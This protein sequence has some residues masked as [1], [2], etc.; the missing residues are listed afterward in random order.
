MVEGDKWL[1]TVFPALVN[2]L[3]IEF[4]ALFV[5]LSVVTIRENTCPVDRESE[6]SETHLSK[7]GNIFTEVMIEINRGVGGIED[8]I[9]NSWAES[10]RSVDIAA[11]E[12]I[13]NAQSLAALK[14]AAF[15]LIRSTCTAPEKILWKS[16][17]YISFANLFPVKNF[18]IRNIFSFN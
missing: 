12:H 3:I 15:V 2:N 8:A 11:E 4:Q 10:A 9:F 5:R 7:E 14:I 6:T 18:A 1:Y 16:H 13:R 17:T